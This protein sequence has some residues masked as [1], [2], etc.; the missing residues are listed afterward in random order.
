M[1]M[2]TMTSEERIWA[3]IR[4]EKPDRTPL[5]PLH[6][7]SASAKLLG[8]DTLTL[9]AEGGD[10][11]LDAELKAF[12]EYGGWDGILTASPDM[13]EVWPLIGMKGVPPDKDH[14]EPQVLEVENMKV[15]DYDIIAEI[16]WEKFKMEQ[17][18]PRITGKDKQYAVSLVD[19]YV[20]LQ[21]KS[22]DLYQKRGACVLTAMGWC[23]HPAFLFSLSRSLMKYTEDLY[24]SPK[25]VERAL[26]VATAEYIENAINLYKSTGF[27]INCCTEERAGAF[28]YPLEIFERFWWPYAKEI[29]DGLWS[30]GIV[31]WFHL[32]TC[33]DKNLPYFKQLPRGS[34]VID[35]DGTTDIFLAK[36]LLRN[37]L[38][39]NSDVHPAL[40]S[41]GKPE[42]VEAYCKKLIDEVGGDGGHM[43]SSGCNLP[44]AI[45]PDNFRAMLKTGKTYEFSKK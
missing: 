11:C 15:E 45:K 27:K 44:A 36:E 28:F 12:D 40:L 33:W 41:L 9:L 8:L 17:L 20:K 38:C 32:D 23:Q 22:V 42:E 29:V 26:K 37:H 6:I 35:L 19:K 2:E 30:E 7:L 24:Y 5:V 21:L 43:L 4:L 14:P 13:P 10:A 25:K 1:T 34:A 16:G 18:I 39:I 31:T 3:A